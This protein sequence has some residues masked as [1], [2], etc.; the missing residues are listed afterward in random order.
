VLGEIMLRDNLLNNLLRIVKYPHITT[1]WKEK[2]LLK[3][4]EKKLNIFEI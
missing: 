1:P 2:S 3:I 4:C